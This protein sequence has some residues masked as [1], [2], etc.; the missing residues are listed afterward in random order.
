MR[1]SLDANGSPSPSCDNRDVLRQLHEPPGRTDSCRLSLSSHAMPWVVCRKGWV[2]SH[3]SWE[4][5]LLCPEPRTTLMGTPGP[6]PQQRSGQEGREITSCEK[7]LRACFAR[8]AD[9]APGEGLRLSP[10]MGRAGCVQ[11]HSCLRVH[12]CLPRWERQAACRGTAVSGSTAVSPDGKGCCVQGRSCLRV[13]KKGPQQAVPFRGS[14]GLGATLPRKAQPR[15][16]FQDP[17]PVAVS[18]SGLRGNGWSGQPHSGLRSARSATCALW[19]WV[20]LVLWSC[21]APW[22]SKRLKKSQSI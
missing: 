16:P 6:S 8:R 18:G 10:Q 17:V 19:C 15:L 3:L 4:P 11:G 20:F 21:S 9:S 13:Q 1:M 7:Q 2:C 5:H 14:H 12:G 22:R